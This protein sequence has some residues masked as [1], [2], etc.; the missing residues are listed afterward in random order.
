M[1]KFPEKGKRSESKTGV[2]S[3]GFSFLPMQILNARDPTCTMNP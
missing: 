2:T 3:L 1:K